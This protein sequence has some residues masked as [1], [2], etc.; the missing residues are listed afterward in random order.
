MDKPVLNLWVSYHLVFISQLSKSSKYTGQR[1]YL[2]YFTQ[3]TKSNKYMYFITQLTSS[4]LSSWW[5]VIMRMDV[6]DV[7][8]SSFTK[9]RNSRLLAGALLSIPRLKL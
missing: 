3:L 5:L 4:V 1:N 7:L 8:G 9:E 2:R 6:N